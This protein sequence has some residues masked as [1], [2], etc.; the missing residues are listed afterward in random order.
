[1]RLRHELGLQGRLK[2]AVPS[3]EHDMELGP[4][5]T[6][7][8]LLAVIGGRL[9]HLRDW[10]D[11]IDDGLAW[12]D[13]QRTTVM[14]D[15]PVEDE[16]QFWAAMGYRLALEERERERWQLGLGPD[17]IDLVDAELAAANRAGRGA[18]GIS[19]R[20]RAELWRKV[21]S[22]PFEM[23]GDRPLWVIL[24]YPREWRL[25]VPDRGALEGHR[26]A[27]GER[28]RRNFGEPNLRLTRLMRW[29]RVARRRQGRTVGGWKRRRSWQGIT[30]GGIGPPEL[31]RL[32]ARASDAAARRQ[33]HPDPLSGEVLSPARA[34][35]RGDPVEHVGVHRLQVAAHGGRRVA[36]AEDPLDVQQIEVVRAVRPDSA[37]QDAGR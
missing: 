32:L 7:A 27:F 6:G 23:L 31:A 19:A 24:T 21:L 35:S 33:Q 28:W 15:D 16:Y 25:R 10:D 1:V 9:D 13:G 20:S 14:P 12:V 17:I 29:R 11:S 18:G 5:T 4:R 8:E 2:A 3:P 34:Q 30:V 22:L 36:V 37:V 26:R